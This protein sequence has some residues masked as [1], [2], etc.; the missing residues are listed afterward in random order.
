MHAV[1]LDKGT[2][3]I[4]REALLRQREAGCTKRLGLFRIE[5]PRAFLWGGEGLLRD[6]RPVGEITSAGYSDRLGTV[7][8]MGYVR[9]DHLIDRA[10]V[11]AGTYE[12]DIA[13]ERVK[14]TALEKPPYPG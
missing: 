9:A 3:F 4:G 14:A 8:A 6:G 13:G 2:D 5:D 12:V 11:L 7:V 10:H 1:K